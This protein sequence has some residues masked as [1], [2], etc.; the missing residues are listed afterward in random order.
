MADREINT[1][2]TL[3]AFADEFAPDLE[4]QMKLLAA[5]EINRIDLRTVGG[6]NVLRLSDQEVQHIKKRLD[7]HG[8]QIASIA[9]PIGAIGITDEF[10]PH[11]KDFFRAVDL[12]K[13][14]GT[15]YIRIFSF[16]IPK[17][18]DKDK[19]KTEVLSRMTE[20]TRIAEQEG[21]VLLI[22]NDPPYYV[23][24]GYRARDILETINS[25]HLRLAFDPGNFVRAP[26]LPMTDA[27]PLVE[28]YISYIHMKDA[29]INTGEAV[30]SGDGDGE[31]RKLIAALKE[32]NY[33]GIISVEPQGKPGIANPDFSVAAVKALK[34]LLKEAG[35]GWKSMTAPLPPSCPPR[36]IP[37]DYLTHWIPLSSLEEMAKTEYDVLIVGT[38]AGG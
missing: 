14:F 9:S 4:T 11:L 10:A 28:P 38:G 34:K 1:L 13:F 23:D 35:V 5:E 24:N 12:A 2:I 25:P 15:P 20:L 33:S 32:K 16:R 18:E 30:L 37:S 27:Y 21:V 6:I 36:M 8:F 31:I 26:V 19:Y 29:R 7:A 17:G 22:D 3:S